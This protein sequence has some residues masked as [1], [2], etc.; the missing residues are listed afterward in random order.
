MFCCA[1]LAMLDANM[2]WSLLLWLV[3][4]NESPCER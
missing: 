3:I 1:L 4:A 2:E